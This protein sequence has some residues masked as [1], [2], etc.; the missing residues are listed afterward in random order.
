M[1]YTIKTHAFITNPYDYKP[2]DGEGECVYR[3]RTFDVMSYNEKDRY[4]IW[5]SNDGELTDEEVFATFPY[6][7]TDIENV[8]RGYFGNI[9]KTIIV[10]YTQEER[11]TWSIQTKECEL[12]NAD[13]TASTPFLDA[14]STARGITKEDLVTKIL[15]NEAAFKV[16]SGTILGKQQAVL[17]TYATFTKF[18][19]Y[20]D[21]KFWEQ[22]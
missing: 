2:F 16:A 17:D 10:P 13:P 11:E 14:L 19:E 7:K 8:A 4:E 18:S 5:A 6:V 21:F 20:L 9:L 3:P 12:F 15:E 22:V 1:K